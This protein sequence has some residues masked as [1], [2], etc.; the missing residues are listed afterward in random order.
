MK[1]FRQRLRSGTPTF[2]V[3]PNIADPGFLEVLA[4]CGAEAFFFDLEQGPIDFHQLDGLAR[5]ARGLGVPTLARVFS[6]E[7]WVLEKTLLRGVDGIVVPRQSDPD[8][9]HRIAADIAYIRPSDGDNVA[10]VVQIEDKPAVDRLDALMA[11]ERIDVLFPGPV[12]LSKSYGFKGQWKEPPFSIELE[13]IVSRIVAAR[14]T[15]A[16]FVDGENVAAWANRGVGLF[17][18]HAR[19]WLRLGHDV[20]AHNLGK[21]GG[22]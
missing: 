15:A 2:L 4:K 21:A 20:F 11:L 6:V 3:N 9:I 13:K 17:Y 14:G 8:I 1:S 22:V 5:T 18:V 7:P 16:M 19:E 12:D 10:L